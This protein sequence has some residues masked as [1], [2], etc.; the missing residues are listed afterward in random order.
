MHIFEIS[1]KKNRNGR[2]LFSA[3]LYELQPPECV[4]DD[5]G[6]KFNLN[7]ITFLE[8][9]ASKHLDS[10]KDMSVTVEFTDEERIEICAHGDT[11]FRED[12][13]PVFEKATVVGHFTEGYIADIQFGEEIKRCVCG[14]GYLDEMRYYDFVQNLISKLNDGYVIEGSIEI[15]KTENNKTILYKNGCIPKGRIPTEYIHTGWAMVLNPSDASSTLLEI[16]SATK[17][18]ETKIME[19]NEQN[20]INV[21]QKSMS[22]S[23][24]VKIEYDTKITELN[25]QIN[26]RDNTISELNATIEQVRTALE[27]LKSEQETSWDERRILEGELAKLRA[28]KRIN[29]LNAAI[30]EYSETEIKYAESEINAFKQDP[31]KGDV[32]S[33]TSKICVGIVAASKKAS[34]IAEQ[35][36]A[37]NS[38]EIDIFSEINSA[39]DEDEDTDIFN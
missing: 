37:S 1:S 33:I 15:Y 27:T 30:A 23:N 11:G 20:I 35:N 6:T 10:I 25:A 29:E 12:D 32:N 19:M 24:S 9:Y 4:I 2:R 26:E 17:K 28:E 21:I 5:I 22:E 39:T 38:N 8:K 3:V 13:F 16:N 7:G 36:S 18:E 31:L 34:K 14:K